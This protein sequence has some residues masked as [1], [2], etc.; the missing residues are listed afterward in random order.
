MKQGR[1]GFIPRIVGA[2][3]LGVLSHGCHAYHL[4]PRNTSPVTPTERVTL[5]SFA[6]GLVQTEHLTDECKGRGVT[7]VAA[8][9]N[10]A[11]A[12]AGVV[13]LGL[14]MPLELEWQCAGDP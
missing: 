5:H 10:Y 1:S 11:Y 7:N 8:R 2:V 3:A 12:L 14:W 9:T 13:S 4:T 6:W